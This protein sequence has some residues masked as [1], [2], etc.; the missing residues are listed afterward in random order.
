MNI[1]FRD[2]MR[3][4]F[5]PLRRDGKSVPGWHQMYE[6]EDCEKCGEDCFVNAVNVRIPPDLMRRLSVRETMPLELSWC[7]SFEG[8][9]CEDCYD[10]EG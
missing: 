4:T 1:S 9:V 7:D 10:W 2:L 8:A 6:V 5:T 3:H